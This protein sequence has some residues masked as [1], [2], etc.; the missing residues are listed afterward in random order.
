MI[1]M[2]EIENCLRDGS[3]IAIK[4]K[5]DKAP[6][7]FDRTAAGISFSNPDSSAYCCILGQ[8][9][10]LS[11]SLKKPLVLLSEYE[12]NLPD[13]LYEK[14]AGDVRRLFCWEFYADLNE[15]TRAHYTAFSEYMVKRDLT[16]ISLDKPGLS[17]WNTS[18]LTIKQW[19]K[20]K[21]L[22]IPKGTILYN[23][24]GQ[25]RDKDRKDVRKPFFNAVNGLRCALS[26]FVQSNMVRFQVPAEVP[27]ADYFY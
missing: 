24:L 19:I 13:E 11:K 15:H 16:R 17:D 6:F 9:A 12:A 2:K 25:M 27:R 26:A 4:F 23:Q 20:D 10:G 3:Y 7:M 1:T 21:A 14:I 5:E 22:E 8:E 18:I